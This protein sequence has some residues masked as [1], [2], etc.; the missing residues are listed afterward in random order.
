MNMFSARTR[1]CA[2]ELIDSAMRDGVLVAAALVSAS[3]AVAGSPA[4]QLAHFG[5]HPEESWRAI[6]GRAR[7]VEMR[8]ALE[9]DELLG[10]ERESVVAEL[11]RAGRAIL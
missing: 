3:R 5:G 4:S 6:Y 10:G 7:G 11:V 9:L 1:F 8:V 2:N